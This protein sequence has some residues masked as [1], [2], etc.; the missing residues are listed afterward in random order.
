MA[1]A[2]RSR[3]LY[4][5]FAGI[6][7][8][9]TPGTQVGDGGTMVSGLYSVQTKSLNDT[10][11][12][13]RW[14]GKSEWVP[15]SSRNG[16]LQVPLDVGNAGT[17]SQTDVDSGTV[18]YSGPCPLQTRRLILASA[19]GGLRAE[20]TLPVSEVWRAADAGIVQCA[21]GTVRRTVEL[22]GQTDAGFVLHNTELW[23][24]NFQCDGGDNSA[25]RNDWKDHPNATCQAEQEMTFTVQ[26]ACSAPGEVIQI[27]T[28]GGFLPPI[29]ELL[30]E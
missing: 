27:P 2:F 11:S 13:A 1:V 19:D 15:V 4:L 7:S 26:R 14:A 16:E 21:V 12:P 10:C 28:D 18:V 9:T 6:V 23:S 30:C 3:S 20:E 17:C 24:I 29:T 22:K 25:I 8:C 5:F